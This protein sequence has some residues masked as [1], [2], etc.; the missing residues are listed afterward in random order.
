MLR[1]IQKLGTVILIG[2]CAGYASSMIN[3]LN[4]RAQDTEPPRI[5]LCEGSLPTGKVKCTFEDPK[6]S[7]PSDY[8]EGDFV[9]GKPEGFMSIPQKGTAMR[10]NSAMVYPTVKENIFLRM[11]LAGKVNSEMVSLYSGRQSNQM[12]ISI[13]EGLSS[14]LT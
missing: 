13:W 6:G 2:C 12:A 1:S 4:V 8:Y 11:I 9:N 3:T 14:F 5:P 10:E 7:K